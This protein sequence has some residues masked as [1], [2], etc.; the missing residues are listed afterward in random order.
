MVGRTILRA[1]LAAALTSAL[2]LLA[3]A[4]AV[5]QETIKL[6]APETK[7]GMPLMDALTLRKSTR[8]YDDRALP[9]QVLSNL[10][11]AAFGINRPESGG[12][13]APSARGANEI[14][15]YVATPDAVRIYDPKANEL[16]PHVS[17]D[18]RAKTSVLPFVRNAPVVLIYVADR[19]RM[20]KQSEEEQNQNAI[21]DAAIIGQNVYLF[22]ASAGLG[23]VILGSVDRKALPPAIN[24]RTDQILTYT[25]PVGYPK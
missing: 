16:R 1:G 9:P 23:T 25:Q 2:L 4:P 15:I 5:A 12:R 14:D 24:L 11:W 22:A 19:V 6:P 8:L 21:A 13:T 3:P 18:V 20:P 10:L 17:G 7:G